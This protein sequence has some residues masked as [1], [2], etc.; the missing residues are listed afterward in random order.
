[1]ILDIYPW[2]HFFSSGTASTHQV[3]SA[4][5][6]DDGEEE[7]EERA[8]DVVDA[9]D[10]TLADLGHADADPALV[11]E[12]LPVLGHQPDEQEADLKEGVPCFNI[13]TSFHL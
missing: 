11:G 9:D 8:P 12:A 2:R 4:E 5:E 7:E 1:M 13:S 10:A 6:W 3:S